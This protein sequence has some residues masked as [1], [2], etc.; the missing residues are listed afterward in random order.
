ML[1]PCLDQGIGPTPSLLLLCAGMGNL[2]QSGLIVGSYLA[3][4]KEGVE[5]TILVSTGIKPYTEPVESFLS[6][7]QPRTP[8]HHQDRGICQRPP[9]STSGSYR[10]GFWCQCCLPQ[11]TLCK[12]PR[13]RLHSRSILPSGSHQVLSVGLSLCCAL[14]STKE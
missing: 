11:W 9:S 8:S 2:R 10:V 5:G 12:A 14:A 6:V 3:S 13:L 1:C 7:T 4:S